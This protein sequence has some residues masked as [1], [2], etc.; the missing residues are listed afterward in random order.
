MLKRVLQIALLSLLMT[1]GMVGASVTWAGQQLLTPPWAELEYAKKYLWVKARASV[2]L[3]PVV[4]ES[5][6]AGWPM[7]SAVKPV[8]PDG[9]SLW[10]MTVQ[11]HL[12]NSREQ[13]LIWMDPESLQVFQR[14]RISEGKQRR[15]K[16]YRLLEQGI[17]RERREPLEGE[18]GLPTDQWSKS[19]SVQR[20]FPEELPDGASLLSPYAL[21]VAAS[22]GP[23]NQQGDSW[24]Q[25]L[26]TDLDYLK[27]D[28][29]VSGVEEL[30]V[31]YKLTQNGSVREV[32]SD[33]PALVIELHVQPIGA[34]PEDKFELMGLT[35]RVSIL[36]DPVTRLPLQIRGSAPNMGETSIDLVRAAVPDMR[37]ALP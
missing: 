17:Y 14:S 12:A 8:C 9:D 29:V 36:I 5:A 1:T 15:M 33:V 7:P 31:N 19:S 25:Y 34:V 30:A 2:M 4:A 20:A 10:Q 11:S 18:R 24:T 13:V 28:M 21:L 6:V 3:Q 27:V 35:G 16:Q 26:Y 22:S 23:L 32:K 37:G